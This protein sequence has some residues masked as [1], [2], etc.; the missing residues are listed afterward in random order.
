MKAT[1]RLIGSKL[2]A[3]L[4]WIN[5]KM[6]IIFHLLLL[7]RVK[8]CTFDPIFETKTAG[9]GH[10]VNL[11]CNRQQLE[12]SAILFWIRLVSG[13]FP[14]IL[15]A[16]FSHEHPGVNT[17][18]HFTVKQEPG[19]FLLHIKKTE[20]SHTGVY[21]CI[22]VNQLVMTFLNA[23]FLRIKGPEPDVSTVIQVPPSDPVG[24]G[25]PV[26]LQCSVLSDSENNTCP[27]YHSVFWFRSGSDESHASLIHAHGNSRDECEKN[28]EDHWPQKC[29]YNFCKNVSSSDAGTHYCAVATC[30]EIL[31]GRGTKVDNKASNVWDVQ[32]A[33]TVLFLLCAT[34]AISLIVI[35]FLIHIIKKKT[36]DCCK[37]AATVRGNQQDQQRDEDS[38]VYSAP[39]FTTRKAG[40][41][42]RGKSKTTEE[43]PV[44]S[45][46]RVYASN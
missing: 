36:C 21:Y 46:V 44:Y 19:V 11:T 6:R 33:N 29:V 18:S 13:N 8:R 2:T 40:K 26:T 39:T 12:H 28:P 3:E 15:G 38:L 30:G 31:F 27:G 24:P 43:Q 32:K 41:A 1:H 35:G 42:L 45:D 17:T 23:T 34:L 22:R 25:D 7:L 16:T 5:S 37:E 9:V 10:D 4:K 14:E 20:R